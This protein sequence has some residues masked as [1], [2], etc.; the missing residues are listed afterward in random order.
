MA[1]GRGDVADGK[2]MASQRCCGGGGRGVGRAAFDGRITEGR[3]RERDEA[4]AER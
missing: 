3:G 1:S 4:S 2:D